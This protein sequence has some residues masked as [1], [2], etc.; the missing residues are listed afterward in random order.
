MLNI[1]SSGYQNRERG[2][3]LFSKT[4]TPAHSY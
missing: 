4:S 1:N 3:Y 2:K